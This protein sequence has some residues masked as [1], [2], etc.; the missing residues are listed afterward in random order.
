[1]KIILFLFVL[2]SI[3]LKSQVEHVH[4]Y[5]P[6]YDYLLRLE[7]KGYL[8]HYSLSDLPM[9]RQDI[10][11]ILTNVDSQTLS[12]TE[13][14]THKLFLQEF[15]IIKNQNR[16]LIPS[17][18][19]SNQVFFEP[20]I[21]NDE[22]FFYKLQGNNTVS[23]RPLAN[24]ELRFS[25][26]DSSRNALL[27]NAGTRIYGTIDNVLGYQLQVTNGSQLTGDKTLLTEDPRLGQNVKFTVYDSDFD[28]T[29]SHVRFQYDWFYAYVGRE[30]R[31]VGSGLNQKLIISDLS[32][33][34][35]AF[36]IGAKFKSFEYKHTHASLISL[37]L[38]TQT[39]GV[40]SEFIE[41]Y[42]VIH[43][44]SFRPSWGEISIWEE[45]TYTNRG[46]DIAYLNPLSFFKSLEHA[47]R[48][49]D[50]SVM[51]FD[52]VIRPIKNLQLKG[53]YLLDDIIFEEIGNGFWSNKSAY[54]FSAISSMP[55]GFDLG[56]EYARNEPYV[57]S[58]FD[59]QQSL[60]NDGILF[61]GY[62]PPNS[63]QFSI[64]LQKWWGNRFPL[65]ANFSYLRHGENVV[66]DGNLIKNVGGDPLQ[67]NRFEDS[68]T[69]TFL[70]GNLIEVFTG[71]FDFTFEI[72]RGFN[73][74]LNYTLQ[75]QAGSQLNQSGR[76]GIRFG[77]FR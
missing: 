20:L 41:K 67:T 60:T 21:G 57:F 31:L 18:T 22:K 43:R 9:Q 23:I 1:M 53:T 58:H 72:V 61:A 27:A 19:D 7:T 47:L 24:L 13:L 69:V 70:D 10:I 74:Q 5:H 37:P 39:T 59:N 50:N 34:F 35:D 45:I 2:I 52:F 3:T 30:N 51:G 71:E 66:I 46:M 8:K 17:D 48:D 62:I 29:E 42:L 26:Q 75:K 25:H 12:K 64:L 77:E 6:V 28:F 56:F 4:V 36:S 49:R 16:V 14:K 40:D 73:L 33:P 55:L 32:T 44:A 15:E 65:K 54:N 68:N 38:S 63:E 11:D 76:I